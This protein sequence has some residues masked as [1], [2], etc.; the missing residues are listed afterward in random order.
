MK[1]SIAIGVDSVP[2]RGK[3]EGRIVAVKPS[4]WKWGTEEVKQFLILEVDLGSSIA[5]IEDAQKL[6]VPHFDTGDLWWPSS[7]DKDGN[8]IEPP[9]IL[10]KRRYNIPLTDLVAKA[11]VLGKTIDLAKVKDMGVEYQPIK[12]ITIPF[13]TMILDRVKGTKLIATDL[14][15]INNAGK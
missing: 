6:T 8:P 10:A 9:K 12:A 5:T 2:E 4:G 11:Q 1:V 14:V 7:E 3:D 15:E 13:A